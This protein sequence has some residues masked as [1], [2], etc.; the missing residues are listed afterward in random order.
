M[1]TAEKTE[2]TEKESSSDAKAVEKDHLAGKGL[3]SGWS[4]SVNRAEPYMLAKDAD[5]LLA[6]QV[7]NNTGPNGSLPTEYADTPALAT[8]GE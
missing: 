3:K 6:D 4:W 5:K 2:S 7:A 8:K 1:A